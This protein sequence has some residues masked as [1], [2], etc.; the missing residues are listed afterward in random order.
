M[1]LIIHVCKRVT[2]LRV[3]RRGIRHEWRPLAVIFH[4]VSAVSGSLQ[5]R[6][7]SDELIYSAHSLKVPNVDDMFELGAQV[8]EIQLEKKKH[9]QGNVDESVGLAR[10]LLRSRATHW[11]FRLLRTAY[12]QWSAACFTHPGDEPPSDHSAI[13][14]D[15]GFKGT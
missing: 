4:R 13:I 9:E 11:L 1:S 12:D 10:T 15:R 14:A 6:L 2:Q 5:C 8:I 3:K 7:A